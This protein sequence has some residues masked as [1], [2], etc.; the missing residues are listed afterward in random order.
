MGL[1]DQL[2][3]GNQQKQQQ[4]QNFSNQWSPNNPG[5]VSDQE[6]LNHY[7]EVAT[8]LPPQDYEQAAYQAF[9]QMSPQQ[10]AEFARYMQQQ[11]QQQGYQ[12]PQ[13]QQQGGGQAYEDPRSLAQMTAQM[14][15]QQPGMLGQLLGGNGSGNDVGQLIQSP[16][17]KVALAG[18]AAMALKNMMG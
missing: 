5:A 15:Q 17:A 10:R 14:H 8:Q 13:A 18:I 6:A 12:I 2:L 7:Q 3:G 16:V 1:L 4:Y 11:A 9:Q